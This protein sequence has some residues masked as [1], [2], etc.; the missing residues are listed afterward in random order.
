MS[1]LNPLTGFLN[2]FSSQ[3][4]IRNAALEKAV[5]ILIQCVN[6]AFLKGNGLMKRTLN[7][8]L[9]EKAAFIERPFVIFGT[10]FTEACSCL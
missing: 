8:T 9:S 10:E 2:D 1:D 7:T 6:C 5:G 3:L 4:C